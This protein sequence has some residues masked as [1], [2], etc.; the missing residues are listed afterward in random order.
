M[1]RFIFWFLNFFLKEISNLSLYLMLIDFIFTLLEYLLFLLRLVLWNLIFL[2]YLF[3]LW[4]PLWTFTHPFFLLIPKC[5][6]SSSLFLFLIHALLPFLIHSSI[7]W[8]FTTLWSGWFLTTCSLRTLLLL[9]WSNSLFLLLHF[10]LLHIQYC[11]CY[12]HWMR[13]NKM[14]C[15]IPLLLLSVSWWF[16]FFLEREDALC[17]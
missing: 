16:K 12:S 17:L 11:I 7:S 13:P 1:L 15:F 6:I 8:T 3:S 5:K 2:L 14:I 9:R 4:I 10:Y